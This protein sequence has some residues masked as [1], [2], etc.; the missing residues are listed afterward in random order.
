MVAS[1]KVHSQANSYL[2]MSPIHAIQIFKYLSYIRAALLRSLMSVARLQ[3]G[4]IIIIIIIVMSWLT[5]SYSP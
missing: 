2:L 3:V 4:D 5:S 1:G